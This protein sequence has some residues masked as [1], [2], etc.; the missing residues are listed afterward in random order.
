MAVLEAMAAGLPAL[1]TPGCNFVEAA[2]AGAA[3]EYPADRDGMRAALQ[4]LLALHPDDLAAMGNRARTL[5][6]D[7][8][9]W[10]RIASLT[11]ELYRWLIAGQPAAAR[12]SFL[13]EG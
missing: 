13:F 4:Q 7:D 1:I 11:Q 6:A 2:D 8:Y 10:D 9:T 3:A 12:P 5:V